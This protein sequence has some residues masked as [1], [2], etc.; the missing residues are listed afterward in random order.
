MAT[1][2]NVSLRGLYIEA[3]IVTFLGASGMTAADKGKAVTLDTS[4]ANTVKLAGNG[5]AILGILESVE[6]R[7]QD[8]VITCAVATRGG[9]SFALNPNATASSPDELPVVGEFIEGGTANDTTKGYVQKLQSGTSKWQVVEVIGTAS[10]V[11]VA[12]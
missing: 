10:V 5:D 3:F 9:F 11:A 2:G 7:A 4:A 12:F 6:V 8:G 1:L